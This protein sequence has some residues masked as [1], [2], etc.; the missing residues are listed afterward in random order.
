M[1]NIDDFYTLYLTSGDIKDINNMVINR[2]VL[3][4]LVRKANAYD[5]IIQ[6]AKELNKDASSPD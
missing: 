2:N 6:N 4:E 1:T 5:E 3:K